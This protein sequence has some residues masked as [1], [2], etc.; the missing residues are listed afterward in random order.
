MTED[1][2]QRRDESRL[3]PEDD[4]KSRNVRTATG[5]VTCW[6]ALFAGLFVSGFV[7]AV[8]WLVM[9][10]V[11]VALIVFSRKKSVEGNPEFGRGV[12]LGCLTLVGLLILLAGV[13]FAFIM[14]STG[15]H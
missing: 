7:P 3:H 5:F 4:S 1:R 14:V 6:V 15:S 9:I 10:G 2:N 11:L 8:S 13:C 12:K